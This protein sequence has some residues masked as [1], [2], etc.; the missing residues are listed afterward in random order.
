MSILVTCFGD[1]HSSELGWLQSNSII[2]FIV[3]WA[4]QYHHQCFP[5]N[6]GRM[7][8]EAIP[9]AHSRG[10]RKKFDEMFDTSRLTS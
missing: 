10:D 3:N 2:D 6:G 1:Y 4:G 8:M 7:G 5:C 9:N